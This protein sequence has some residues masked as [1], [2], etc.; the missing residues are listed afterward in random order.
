MA[1]SPSKC[2][3]QTYPFM[4]VLH[5]TL[6]NKALRKYLL[7]DK[8]ILNALSELTLN[9]LKQNIGV[10]SKDKKKLVKF[11]KQLSL[12]VKR[13]REREKQKILNSQRGGQLLS[14]LLSIGLPV[15]TSLLLKNGSNN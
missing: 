10:S 15:L 9:I 2:V 11:S 13:G 5:K 14:T 1:V 12:L 4:I 7:K 6:R 3:K 8:K